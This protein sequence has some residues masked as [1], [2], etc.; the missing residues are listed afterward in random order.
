MKNIKIRYALCFALCLA[1]MLI[2]A[3]WADNSNLFSSGGL[4]TY[5]DG[6]MYFASGIWAEMY[7]NDGRETGLPDSAGFYRIADV[8]GAEKELLA[9]VPAAH[10]GGLILKPGRYLIPAG[11]QLYFIREWPTEPGTIEDILARVDLDSE[12]VITIG[13]TNRSA[14]GEPHFYPDGDYVY[15]RDRYGKIMKLDQNTYEAI[16]WETQIQCSDYDVEGMDDAYVRRYLFYAYDLF[17]IQDGYVYYPD[18]DPLAE[19]PYERGSY[20]IYRMP[21][22][23]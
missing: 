3:A 18:I 7:L 2:S 17:D 13:S 6:Y 20:C 23:G 9:S 14:N 11:N 10:I 19:N 22:N 8:P 16:P 4:Y 5:Q 21:V 12:E 1:A 15:F